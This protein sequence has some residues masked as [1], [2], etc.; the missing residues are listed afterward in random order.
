MQDLEETEREE[1]GLTC[2]EAILTTQKVLA[3]RMDVMMAI[4]LEERE[5]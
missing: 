4:L 5:A 1:D 2:D 3:Q